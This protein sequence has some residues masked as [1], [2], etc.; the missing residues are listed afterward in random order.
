M[1]PEPISLLIPLFSITALLSFLLLFIL[2]LCSALISGAEVAVFSLTKTD[3]EN[4]E[5]DKRLALISQLLEKPKKLLATILALVDN[6]GFVL[7]RGL[8][9]LSNV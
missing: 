3:L 7:N 1:D 6:L 4:A 8:D 2:L 9:T 5:N